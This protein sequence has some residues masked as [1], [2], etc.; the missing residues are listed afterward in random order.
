MLAFLRLSGCSYSNKPSGVALAV[1]GPPDAAKVLVAHAHQCSNRAVHL[2]RAEVVSLAEHWMVRSTGLIAPRHRD[3]GVLCCQR[4][5]D[6][7]CLMPRV[8]FFAVTFYRGI[9]KSVFKDLAFKMAALVGNRTSQ[10][11]N[12]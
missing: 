8:C 6:P 5:E 7:L 12:P 11:T 1:P 3:V 4:Q 9:L 10:G 2:G